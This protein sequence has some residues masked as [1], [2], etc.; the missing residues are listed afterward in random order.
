[1]IGTAPGH[2]P[3][4]GPGPRPHGS[5][6]SCQESRIHTGVR[7]DSGEERKTKAYRHFFLTGLGSRIYLSREVLPG[8][9]EARMT[10]PELLP[11]TAREGPEERRKG[12]T[13]CLRM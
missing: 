12:A 10:P 9:S 2:P 1:M 3:S 13:P 5:G 8:P 4:T 11:G 7:T 6:R